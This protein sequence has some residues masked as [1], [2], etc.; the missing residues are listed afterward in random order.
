M[1]ELLDSV[2]LLPAARR[3][4]AMGE[5]DTIVLVAGIEVAQTAPID[6]AGLRK[7]WR[8]RH[9]GGVTPLL[10]LT[11]DASRLG[12]TR[13]IGPTDGNG[14][15]RSVD[16]RSLHDVLIRIS[17]LP[18]LTAVRELVA[19]L[20][21]L[22]QSGIPG[23][24]LHD[25]LTVHTLD[26]RLRSDSGRWDPLREAIAG[27]P[28][29]ADWKQ[30]LSTLGYELQRRPQGDGHLARYEGR[31]VAVVHPKADPSAFSR[32]DQDGRPPEGLLL[33]DCRREG[34]HYGL[35]V[36]GSRL[37]LFSLNESGASATGRY[38]D[39]DAATLDPENRAYLGLLGPSWLA[40]DGFAGLEAEARAFGTNLR[41]RLDERLRQRVL[42]VLARALSEWVQEQGLDLSDDAL[43]GDLRHAA[44]TV[45]F[46]SLF[47]LYA[48]GARYL[49]IDHPA[50]RP[51][52]LT[53]LAAEAADAESDLDPRSSS[54]WDRFVALVK[55]LRTGDTRR[56]VP[57]YNG[58]LFSADGI[59]GAGLLERMEVSDAD[60]GR[61][62]A[63][64]VRDPD[65]PHGVDYSTLEI[66]HLGHIYEGLL[67][68]DLSVADM[69]LHYD[70][71]L[72][73]YI[74]AETDEADVLPGELLW[75]THEGGRKGGGVYYTRT[76]LV[77]HLVRQT[78]VPA[79][80]RHLEQVRQTAGA[81]PARA[82][83]DLFDF[84]VLDP[85]CGSAHFLVVVVNELAD[86]VVSF[87]AD[88]PLPQVRADLARL[89][90]G[91][92]PGV[93]VEDVALMRRLVLKRCV[94]GVDL[95]P[96]GA[97]IAKLS[98]WLAAFVP[99]LS[100]AYLDR[101]VRVGN[102][103]VG[104][105]DPASM[106]LEGRRAYD[107]SFYDDALKQ[108]ISE[109]AE[110]AARVAA[111]DDRTPDEYHAS[112]EAD[113]EAEAATANL[114]R[115]FDLWTAEP[116]GVEGARSCAET[117]GLSVLNGNGRDLVTR[118]EA[119]AAEHRFLHWPTAFPQVFR[120]D[121]P[122]FDA[123]IGNPPW[124][125][126]TVEEQSFYALFRP[127]IRRGIPEEAREVAVA[128]LVAERP[129]L[130]ERLAAEQERAATQRAY[131]TAAEYTT[132]VGDPDLYK[133]FCQRYR[134]LVR[135]GGVLGVVLPRTTFVNKGS[136]QFRSW[137]FEGMTC[138]R[139]DF[140]VNAGR[141][142]FDSEPRYTV[143][144]VAARQSAP[145]PDHTVQI[146]GTA[147]SL[148]DWARQTASPGLALEYTAFGPGWAP[149]LV[150]SQAEADVLAK[151]R[152]GSPFP[153][154][155]GGRWRCFPIAELHETHNRNLWRNAS[156]GGALWKGESF[157]Q[158]H[159]HGGG[160]RRIPDTP[161]LR[162]KITK[163]R[164]GAGSVLAAELS[165][166]ERRR[167]MLQE[168]DRAR[169]AFTDVTQKDNSR[170]VIA[171]LVPP[172]VRL[173]NKAPY[174]T[175][176]QSDRLGRAACLGVL[177]SLPFDW[178]ARRFVEV[179]LNFF[180]LE[181]LV[182]PTLNDE[183]YAAVATAA[184]RLSCVDERFSDFAA[185]TGV[186]VGPLTDAERERLRVE[187]D[188]RVAH[189]WRLTPDDLEVIYADF[190]LG[191]V[192]QSY[193]E[194]LTRRLGEFT[195]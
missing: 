101:N 176:P 71:A 172:G 113:Q 189:A 59:K 188:A 157:D 192:A 67:S 158:Y 180:I 19:D 134:T 123:V 80:E 69:P 139:I 131:F 195:P 127:G 193:R 144:L 25:L 105:A 7:L 54:L 109:A 87:L 51:Y 168:L 53:E 31:P 108:A 96:M 52:S 179:N 65:A 58:A 171:C 50:Y 91:A 118:A 146:A 162:A 150:R 136:R 148:D 41:K 27:L 166:N 73:R 83:R 89:A 117:E 47:I 149:P 160:E 30:T 28:N 72:D 165:L 174:L 82:A 94:Y 57:A 81:D 191:A 95:S 170:T 11:T 114:Q 43:R 10:L 185:E 143:A 48:E 1:S 194:R 4:P 122:G 77:T 74:A 9:R 147:T 78:V 88:T 175:F 106:R 159:P 103:L 23:L 2:Q 129:D 141:W 99:G 38:L 35:L 183:A 140:L 37:R 133:F 66:G 64:L 21:R 153:Y 44:L 124:N 56:G 125:E 22:D 85:A 60:F 173:T 42:P 62:L 104:V 98:L 181:G 116:F 138:E 120:G 29:K 177:N 182:V 15:L 167:A 100:L 97:E 46:R 17:S 26:E 107:R 70:R 112:A 121:R 154:G 20:E 161:A 55:A 92:A 68:L 63:G 156:E 151:L 8:G 126:V 36:S 5:F 12:T 164:P 3:V 184:A 61:A 18:R 186:E 16:T 45:L 6:E 110:A 142:A 187:I 130:P 155:S 152:A 90:A 33:N 84:A 178:Q 79:F 119:L 49:P 32:L 135:D 14:P 40:G 86:L 13:A 24:K 75:Q 34:V 163:P 128:E 137:L 190:T 132:S 102:S 169:V 145:D 76:E 115:L 111:G 39:L 93:P